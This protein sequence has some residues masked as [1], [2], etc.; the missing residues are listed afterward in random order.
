MA[1]NILPG[2]GA[3]D[4]NGQEIINASKAI[5]QWVASTATQI[6]DDPTGTA[7]SIGD[8]VSNGSSLYVFTAAVTH[9]DNAL[10][11]TASVNDIGAGS[12]LP[13]LGFGHVY[14]GAGSG[15]VASISIDSIG[16]V[17]IEDAI[18]EFA[19]DSDFTS[20]TS[21]IFS[22]DDYVYVVNAGGTPR[23]WECDTSTTGFDVDAFTA[24]VIGSEKL[25]NVVLDSASDAAR[26]ANRWI[27][28][29]SWQKATLLEKVTTLPTTRLKANDSVY[30]T[31]KDGSNDPGPYTYSGTAWVATGGGGGGGISDYDSTT[32][33]EHDDIVFDPTTGELFYWGEQLRTTGTA[34][35]NPT[36]PITSPRWTRVGLEAEIE[37]DV[38]IEGVSLQLVGTAPTDETLITFPDADLALAFYDGERLGARTGAKSITVGGNVYSIPEASAVVLDS[39][40]ITVRPSL[41]GS[42]VINGNL[43]FNHTFGKID[44][45]ENITIDYVSNDAVSI[46]VHSVVLTN[47]IEQEVTP[48][49]DLIPSGQAVTDF[50]N[51]ELTQDAAPSVQYWQVEGFPNY[52]VGG[53]NDEIIDFSDF[54]FD[55][56]VVPQFNTTTRSITQTVEFN[57][58]TGANAGQWSIALMDQGYIGV[59][60][61]GVVRTVTLEWSSG[62]QVFVPLH[63]IAFDP[64]FTGAEKIYIG[65]DDQGVF[66]FGLS[67]I[68]GTQLNVVTD[69]ARPNLYARPNDQDVQETGLGV[70]AISVNY[71][72]LTAGSVSRTFQTVVFGL[73]NGELPY[74]TAVLGAQTSASASEFLALGFDTAE[75]GGTANIMFPTDDENNTY[76]IQRVVDE[77]GFGA[78]GLTYANGRAPVRSIAW[79]TAGTT[80]MAVGDNIVHPSD[81]VEADYYFIE[82][83]GFPNQPL[84][85]VA[86]NWG[87]RQD[88]LIDGSNTVKATFSLT[89]D[90]RLVYLGVDPYRG[91]IANDST[92]TSRYPTSFKREFL[93]L[94]RISTFDP[95]EGL[96]AENAY[97]WD[98]QGTATGTDVADSDQAVRE[99]NSINFSHV[100]YNPGAGSSIEGWIISGERTTNVAG[101]IEG[102]AAMML[103]A[104]TEY[105]RGPNYNN[106]GSGP[107]GLIII[108]Q[109]TGYANIH[110]DPGRTYPLHKSQIRDLN[111]VVF[112]GD[113][114]S[115]DSISLAPFTKTAG[116][117]FTNPTY[118][119]IV[120]GGGNRQPGYFNRSTDALF[121]GY[122][123]DTADITETTV[124]WGNRSGRS[125]EATRVE[126]GRI[127][128][129]LTHPNLDTVTFSAI[130]NNADSL[131]TFLAA[132]DTAFE[133]LDDGDVAGVETYG[134]EAGRLTVS[135]V[136][137]D[138]YRNVSVTSPDQRLIQFVRD[139]RNVFLVPRV[140]SFIAAADADEAG[141]AQRLYALSEAFT[142][143]HNFTP[144]LTAGGTVL[145]QGVDWEFEA[146]AGVFDQF[147]IG[148]SVTLVPGTTEIVMVY[149]VTSNSFWTSGSIE[150]TTVTV[151]D[152]YDQIGSTV[153]HVFNLNNTY[154][155]AT[156]NNHQL[157][158]DLGAYLANAL[159][160]TNVVVASTGDLILF[161]VTLTHGAILHE[162][163][164]INVI[165]N[166]PDVVG[167]T[168]G[169]LRITRWNN[170]A[171][172]TPGSEGGKLDIDN[173]PTRDEI[174]NVIN[175]VLADA[176]GGAFG[177]TQLPVVST[178]PDGTELEE[179][180]TAGTEGIILADDFLATK[181]YVDAEA[182]GVTLTEL[183]GA[184]I[185]QEDLQNVYQTGQ[186]VSDFNIVTQG[187]VTESKTLVLA[188]TQYT[189]DQAPV[190]QGADETDADYLARFVI[191]ALA[192]PGAT[193]V[194][195]NGT[196]ITLSN[197][198]TSNFT[199]TYPPSNFGSA[200]GASIREYSRR[201]TPAPTVGNVTRPILSSF[202]SAPDPTLGVYISTYWVAILL[203]GQVWREYQ[204]YLV[205]DEVEYVDSRGI[206]RH[207]YCKFAHRSTQAN[208]P[209]LT[210]AV[211]HN[212]N[213]STYSETSPWEPI[214]ASID[215]STGT[216]TAA[217][218]IFGPDDDDDNPQ[219]A[220]V[221]GTFTN[222]TH[223]G[224]SVGVGNTGIRLTGDDTPT[225]GDLI[226]FGTGSAG[227]TEEYRL[228]AID[229]DSTALLSFLGTIPADAAAL[230][231]DL[232]VGVNLFNSGLRTDFGQVDRLVYA[233]DDFTVNTEAQDIGHAHVSLTG[234]LSSSSLW[235]EELRNNYPASSVVY[236]NIAVADGSRRDFTRTGVSIQAAGS[237]IT[238]PGDNTYTLIEDPN[239][240]FFGLL[241]DSNL[242]WVARYY[243]DIIWRNNTQYYKGDTVQYVGPFGAARR[244]YCEVDHI[245]TEVNNP[246]VLGS[247]R[248]DDST[249]SFLTS[250]PWTPVESAIDISTGTIGDTAV[251]YRHENGNSTQ[252]T[253][254][255][256]DV[257][258]WDSF[259]GTGTQVGQFGI[260]LGSV[261]TTLGTEVEPL[262]FSSQSVTGDPESGD[263]FFFGPTL[264]SHTDDE[265]ELTSFDRI[266]T[267]GLT[268]DITVDI[269]STTTLTA[270]GTNT[271]VVTNGFGRLAIGDTAIFD[272]DG[273]DVTL[274]I[275]A[276][277]ESNDTIGFSN[278]SSAGFD[279]PAGNLVFTQ[280]TSDE[281]SFN[282]TTFFFELPEGTTRVPEHISI[283]DFLNLGDTRDYLGHTNRLVFR[284]DHFDINR[285][286]IGESFIQIDPSF[287]GIT[288]DRVN[289][290]GYQVSTALNTAGDARNF[291]F[292]S[293]FNFITFLNE[294]SFPNNSTAQAYTLGRAVRITIDTGVDPAIDYDFIISADAVYNY[295]SSA[296][297]FFSVDTQYIT[298]RLD[299]AGG[300]SDFGA[301]VFEIPEYQFNSLVAGTGVSFFHTEGSDSLV[302][303]STGG[304]TGT[305]FTDGQLVRLGA[306]SQIGGDELSATGAVAIATAT[307][308]STLNT[309]ITANADKLDGIAV[310]ANNFVAEPLS[311]VTIT[312]TTDSG[313]GVTTAQFSANTFLSS[314]FISIPSQADV[315]TKTGQVEDIEFFLT[316]ATSQPNTVADL[317]EE[318][319]GVNPASGEAILWTGT[320][321]DQTTGWT[322]AEQLVVNTGD[323]SATSLIGSLKLQDRILV[324]LSP[325]KWSLFTVDSVAS[326]GRL[327]IAATGDDFAGN[328]SPIN[329]DS[330][331]FVPDATEYT[332]GGFPV[333]SSIGDFNVTG[334]G[335]GFTLD[336]V[337]GR[338]LTFNQ[339]ATANFNVTYTAEQ[340]IVVSS[341]NFDVTSVLKYKA[342]DDTLS[343]TGVFELLSSGLTSSGNNL[344]AEGNLNGSP[345]NTMAYLAI[346]FNA[347]VPM[348]ITS[349]VTSPAANTIYLQYTSDY[350]GGTPTF[351]DVVNTNSG[352][353][354]TYLNFNN[355]TK[356]GDVIDQK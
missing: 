56:R 257:R 262:N 163:D 73:A 239:N 30:L 298:T 172:D 321:G 285:E 178:N 40:T 206:P 93:E 183:G 142:P 119:A 111:T 35:T 151:E 71:R 141:G 106:P 6:A 17:R 61:N 48:D 104:H 88:F 249:N 12:N 125:F 334:G 192:P 345:V 259:L 185:W 164:K 225:V 204:D 205:G 331:T 171:S 220:V 112:L 313:T 266:E 85:A 222:A 145:V 25:E 82:G 248:F 202:G 87:I 355:T 59:S 352:E 214:G 60:H 276:V 96:V 74:R 81:P 181:S 162:E 337:N 161:Q 135:L 316:E 268:Y 168:Q 150:S 108:N 24:L 66:S 224:V 159:S 153:A 241:V 27:T 118:D 110:G 215:L 75:G 221:L 223:W 134:T 194:A 303:N 177:I 325:T 200:L 267:L 62:G 182:A 322:T 120:N 114:S 50:V 188:A 129:H 160:A 240:G 166:N 335:S 281:A 333:S 306:N 231:T 16:Y 147:R 101:D 139:P 353:T 338:V 22:V 47:Q 252:S 26:E 344:T 236:D 124:L 211:L 137:E 18:H 229:N 250:Q 103:A 127:D 157:A 80:M 327:G 123:P 79:N 89:E 53:T 340:L 269:V 232:S 167:A 312:T 131:P 343:N 218:Q 261:T 332:L 203:N 175:H 46:A 45:G 21:T 346:Q 317:F 156:D 309:S 109:K 174:L 146:T 68:N 210:S 28:T 336:S 280:N 58:A 291:N 256:R 44:A 274:T 216:D 14:V 237:D 78:H 299:A 38:T 201:N 235:Q 122:I 277:D 39:N 113:N 158:R 272:N 283:N 282:Y 279:L 143:E 155:S 57:I 286:G 271:G 165:V 196:S 245:S 37:T 330:I 208:N 186:V 275:T 247:I 136:D 105:D 43:V 356:T 242:E 339:P 255:L 97:P 11:P 228:E 5:P 169:D 42:N 86:Q 314:G 230:F 347:S 193:V 227:T 13:A 94:L 90:A 179:T 289:A 100:Q 180:I 308:I 34:G 342:A 264:L 170:G 64:R 213:G 8:Q 2:F 117:Q 287:S 349:S 33:Y 293:G 148:D 326:N 32:A 301:F 121:G 278:N 318:P 351:V 295:D 132:L 130:K 197:P 98:G 95:D 149:V 253:T 320:A 83:E 126:Q 270:G 77:A 7:Y 226:S 329:A 144:I 84:M 233:V 41:V 354:I 173:L 328:A 187:T 54:R 246:A 29:E 304:G 133:A 4:L 102:F 99:F 311:G 284:D 19:T 107:G 219:A 307:D 305:G 36:P 176:E 190:A 254:Q 52:G 20:N 209:T 70:T 348:D 23:M 1:I 9:T 323:S 189:L 116:F 315:M 184:S 300:N 292:Q 310:N 76:E 51:D 341:G 55:D 69:Y 212:I 10:F 290:V 154:H 324:Y 265:Y 3:L 191:T 260:I 63:C 207:V 234:S 294:F 198:L 115:A 138:N 251:T 72:T 263:R 244:A 152:N 296:G 31:A 258:V 243:V 195:V 350:N 140:D 67:N 65:S 15:N 217:V 273:T 128:V 319:T 49:A 92:Y 297:S 91:R 288:V 302:I 238:R 199:V